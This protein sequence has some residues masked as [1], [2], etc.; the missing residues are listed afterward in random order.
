[1]TKSMHASLTAISL[2]LRAD[3]FPVKGLPGELENLL[4]RL[5]ALETGMRGMTERSA[6]MSQPAFTQPGLRS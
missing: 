5:A 3:Y 4:A 1:M 6:E 2:Q